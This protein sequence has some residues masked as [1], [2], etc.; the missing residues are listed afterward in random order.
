MNKFSLSEIKYCL[1]IIKS[2][3]KEVMEIISRNKKSYDYF[4]IWLDYIQDLDLDFIRSLK[5]ESGEKLI[6]LF[7][8]QCLEKP[9]MD[10]QKR[11]QIINFLA[12]SNCLVDLDIFSQKKELEYLRKNSKK[13]NLI[14]SY[15]NYQKTPSDQDLTQIIQNMVKHKAQIYKISTFCNQDDNALR[16]IDLLT[17]LKSGNQKWIILGM[18]AKGN[19]TRIAGALLGN[20]I[21]FT[22]LS[23]Q[24]NSA[25]G[26]F[27]KEQLEQILKNIKTCYFIADPV[28]HS[29]SPQ[30]HE[31]GYRA[32]GIE[33][34]FLFV[35]KLVKS[36]DLKKF[37]E[38]IRI[39][40]NF[41]GASVSI[42]HKVDVLKYLDQID[43]SAKKIGA[44]N[45]IVKTGKKLKGYNT[46]YLGILKPLMQRTKINGKSV[47]IIGAG[48][49]A[50]AAV[51]A[52]SSQGTKVTI[53]NRDLKKAKLLANEFNCKF[54]SLANLNK[55][56]EFDI[57]INATKI[58]LNPSDTPL[59]DQKLIKSNQ[60]IFDAVYSKDFS[61]T[62]L[63][64]LAKQ[65]RAQTISGIE[66]LLYQGIAQFE[67]FT[68]MKAPA[69]QM[70][71]ALI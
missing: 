64:N 68:K 35:R 66:M 10:F 34:D 38:E 52:L 29:L 43:V 32:L 7:R 23:Q 70:R 55:I 41:A 53:F 20:E 69:A 24:Q 42:P 13:I 49:A 62:K 16:L 30:M 33:K 40:S 1:P 37:I 12:G 17:K 56:S 26:Q 50:R 2:H 5:K 18:G 54:G 48:G 45:T 27:T 71:K 65:Q 28:E 67:L 25:S 63:I 15:H 19:F 57:I 14:V 21:N 6:F 11:L 8:R 31:A 59:I 46:D 39:D 36:Q 58:G 22:P 3:S 60:I 47:A 9:K 51:Y 44:V 4:E 61:E